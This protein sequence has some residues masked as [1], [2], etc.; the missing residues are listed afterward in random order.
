MNRPLIKICGITNYGDGRACL[1]SGA[2]MLGFIFYDKSPRFINPDDAGN[3][4]ARLKAGFKFESVGVF[5]NPAEDYVLHVIK[6]TNVDMLQFHGGESPS[7]IKIFNKKI[8]KAF[9]IK[10]KKDIDKCLEF[11]DIDFFLFDTFSEHQYGGTGRSF[12]WSLLADFKFKEKLFLSGGINSKN[13]G[14][15][16]KIVKPYAIDVSGSLEKKPG[17][18]DKIKIDEFFLCCNNYFS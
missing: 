2:V 10:E 11:K 16:V 8:I 3:I 12:D 14:N 13:I 9:R 1:E 7:F 6:T 15:A 4:I 17:I 18:K 5:V